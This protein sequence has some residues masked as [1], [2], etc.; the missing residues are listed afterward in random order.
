MSKSAYGRIKFEP[1]L[2][3]GTASANRFPLSSTP[4]TIFSNIE[5][6]ELIIPFF[7]S[8]STTYP[9]CANLLFLRLAE[10][11][12]LTWYPASVT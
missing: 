2:G 9:I 10:R 12:F 6:V 5:P 7:I 11:G 4:H 8:I 1:Q 3:F